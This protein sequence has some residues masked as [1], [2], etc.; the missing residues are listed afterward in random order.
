MSKA[1]GIAIPF[2]PLAGPAESQE[3]GAC[4][5]VETEDNCAGAGVVILSVRI[6]WGYVP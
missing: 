2:W 4:G 1:T 6:R 5:K 3:P